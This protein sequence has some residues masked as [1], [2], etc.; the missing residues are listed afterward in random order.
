MVHMGG[1][2]FSLYMIHILCFH[3]FDYILLKLGMPM[4]LAWKLPVYL[5][6]VSSLA[7]AVNRWFEVPVSN[8]LYKKTFK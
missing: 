1:V 2:S 8:Y 4:D 7:I 3:Y 6:A 5:V